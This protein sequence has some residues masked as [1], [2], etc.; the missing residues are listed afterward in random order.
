VITF[1]F[2]NLESKKLKRCRQRP[3][4]PDCPEEYRR[5]AALLARMALSRKIDVVVL[6]ESV[7]PPEMILD[8]LNADEVIYYLATDS[9]RRFT[10]FTAFSPEFFESIPTFDANRSA[11]KSPAH[12]RISVW[13][14][15][16]PALHPILLAAVHLMDVRSSGGPE[17][18]YD[19]ARFAAD[20]LRTIEHGEGHEHTVVIG[21][22]N[23]NPF[24][25][26]MVSPSSFGAAMT[27]HLARQ[28][29]IVGLSKQTLFYNPM[30]DRFG[31]T[32]EGP[33][34][35]FYYGS[36]DPEFHWN[37]LDQVLIRPQLLDRFDSKLLEILDYGVPGDEKT[38]LRT[39]GRHGAPHKEFASDHLPVL[40]NL[41]LTEGILHG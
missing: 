35:T 40:F 1:L 27:R 7:I 12:S 41:N 29:P 14:M 33:P 20:A 25:R 6:A 24:H 15:K 21:D 23:M 32:T 2:W 13:R 31:D 30:W 38:R 36:D 5:L 3:N 10:V 4:D 37:T 9:N 16:P 18:Q 34:G 28:K 11:S 39:K 22:F 26:G 8:H 19:P 17:G